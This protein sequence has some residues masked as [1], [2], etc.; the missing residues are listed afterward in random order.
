MKYKRNLEA[1]P[2]GWQLFAL[3][4]SRSDLIAFTQLLVTYVTRLLAQALKRSLAFLNIADELRRM[5][6]LLLTRQLELGEQ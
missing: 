1:A 5:F 3:G 2:I 6:L 4:S